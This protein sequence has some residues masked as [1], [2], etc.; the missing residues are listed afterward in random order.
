[1]WSASPFHL[2][3]SEILSFSKMVNYLARRR[4]FL[5]P[6]PRT[7]HH[8]M[9][10]TAELWER[11]WSNVNPSRPV[12]QAFTWESPAAQVSKIWPV[13]SHFMQV[14]DVCITKKKKKTLI[15]L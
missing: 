2:D 11:S 7:P 1:M 3:K 8:C 4:R 6:L 12:D 9:D 14:I 13:G 15:V 5:S 10:K